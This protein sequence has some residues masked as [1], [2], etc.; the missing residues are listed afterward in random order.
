MILAAQVLI[1]FV[2]VGTLILLGICAACYL[3]DWLN[4]GKRGD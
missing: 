1:D 3:S 4:R 2:L